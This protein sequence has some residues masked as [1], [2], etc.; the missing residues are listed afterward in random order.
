LAVDAKSLV[1]DIADTSCARKTLTK[2]SR[3]MAK[4]RFALASWTGQEA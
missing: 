3:N 1:N 4:G 2:L